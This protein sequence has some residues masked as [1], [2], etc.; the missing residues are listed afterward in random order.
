MKIRTAI[1]ILALTFSLCFAALLVDELK[2]DS[3]LGSSGLITAG[4]KL[5]IEIG[6]PIAEAQRKMIAKGFIN[7]ALTAPQQC[8]SKDYSTLNEQ[9]KHWHN[10]RMRAVVCLGEENGKVTTISWSIGG[11]E[12]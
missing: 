10:A 12:L 1:L 4:Q 6:T 7:E 3:L 9:V 5:G 11:W 8:H 2:R